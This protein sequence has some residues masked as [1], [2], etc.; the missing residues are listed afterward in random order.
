MT[1]RDMTKRQL[2]AALARYGIKPD[3]DTD[4]DSTTYYKNGL[5][6]YPT[7]GIRG[8][9]LPLKRRARLADLLAKFK[10]V[11][12]LKDGH[13]VAK[14]QR[15]ELEAKLGELPKSCYLSSKYGQG[16]RCTIML[17]DPDEIRAIVDALRKVRRGKT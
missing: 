10:G 17:S 6:G 7:R 11:A 8:R 4:S 15:I 1:D 14:I 2:D 16:L 5:G 12:E 9:Q 13:A 3:G